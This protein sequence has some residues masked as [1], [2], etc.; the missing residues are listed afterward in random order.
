MNSLIL[1]KEKYN[2]FHPHPKKKNS[3]SN[4]DNYIIYLIFNIRIVVL[5]GKEPMFLQTYHHAGI[6]I[7]M[8]GFVVTNNTV[9]G[10]KF[11][12]FILFF[13]L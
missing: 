4:I 1:G 11:Y 13:I 9:A 3:V 8:W 7:L 10:V 6:V 12:F 5:K 2:F